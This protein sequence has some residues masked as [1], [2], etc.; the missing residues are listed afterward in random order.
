V[1]ILPDV[2]PPG[3]R[4]VVCGTAPGTRSARDQAYYAHP[5][6]EFWGVMHRGGV[7]PHRF[8][9]QDYALLPRHGVGL[10]DICKHAF[11]ADSDLA[12][13]DFDAAG[14]TDRIAVAAPDLLAFNG[15]FA[16]KRF[17]GRNDVPYG[18][19]QERIGGTRLYVA[20]STSKLARRY[21]DESIWMT[22]M[23]LAGFT[24][25]STVAQTEP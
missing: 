15:K 16:A 21:W 10:T 17:L 7:T 23:R 18:L 25:L 19:L 13:D 1:A 3:L 22:L 9:P 14:L 5:Q 2:L 8:A 6:N 12:R 24:P 4:F 11:G 20:P